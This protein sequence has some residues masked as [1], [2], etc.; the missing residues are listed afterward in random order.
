[1]S[2]WRASSDHDEIEPDAEADNSVGHIGHVKPFH[3]ANSQEE[4]VLSIG[5]LGE[6]EVIPVI[7]L[8][9]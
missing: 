2:H 6:E 7:S 3:C 1:L 5:Q 4:C 8:Q 9:I